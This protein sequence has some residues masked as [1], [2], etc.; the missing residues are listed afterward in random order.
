MLKDSPRNSAFEGAIGRAVRN[1]QG[2]GDEPP[3]VL[4]VG[5]GSGLLALLAARAGARVVACE[6]NPAVAAVARSVVAANA[7][8][9]HAPGAGVEVVP[10]RSDV[11]M[12]GT[13]LPRPADVYVSETLDSEFLS[14]GMLPTLRQAR[15]D[16]LLRPGASVVPAGGEVLAQLVSLG[17]DEATASGV[18][19]TASLAGFGAAM[20]EMRAVGGVGEGLR[21]LVA[22]RRQGDGV[23]DAPPIALHGEALRGG[24]EGGGG[25]GSETRLGV[26]FLSEAAVVLRFDFEAEL[27]PERREERTL[28]EATAAGCVCRGVL[29]QHQHYP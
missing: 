6:M 29:T 26:A 18:A 17:G 1:H 15:R 12:L 20:L 22:V 16:G 23:V 21:A 25:G 27:L 13:D 14:E 7:S 4:D 8:A 2:G 3:L 9:L 28:V 24:G 5:T 11:L 19:A 10:K